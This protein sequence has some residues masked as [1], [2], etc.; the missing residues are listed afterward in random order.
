MTVTKA[1]MEFPY[2]AAKALDVKDETPPEV[3]DGVTVRDITFDNSVGGRVSAYLVTPPHS[4]KGPH[5]CV[6]WVHW[7]EGGHAHSNR[8]EFLEEAVE[9]AREGVVSLL[10]DCFWATDAKRWAARDGF[11]WKSEAKHDTDLSIKQVVELRRALDLLLAQ[12]GVDKDRLGYVAHDFGAMYGCI[13]AAIDRRPQFY[14]MMAA[15]TTFSEWFLFGSNLATELEPDAEKQ[16]I[17]DMSPLDPTRYI[18]HAA[19]A[20]LYFQFAHADYYVPERTA[21]LLYDAASSPKEI[22][23]YDAGHDVKH[24]SARPDRLGWVRKQIADQKQ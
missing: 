17:K 18:A 4:V 22:A 15:T 1:L 12:P 20:K 9:L 8:K 10:P 6:L 14:V 7:L 24:D 23:W 13:I 2:D 21:Q 3:K 11:W 16:Y 19:P 5:P